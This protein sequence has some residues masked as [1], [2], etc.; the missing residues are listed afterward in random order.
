MAYTHSK[1]VFSLDRFVV[2]ILELDKDLFNKN[3]PILM[4][5]KPGADEQIKIPGIKGL[6][7]VYKQFEF[8]SRK[9]MVV[10]GH[11]DTGDIQKH[12]DLAALRAE[13][14]VC[15][16]QG[17]K[18]R[19][20]EISHANQKI[21]DYQRIMFYF[22][23]TR[24]WACNP[25]NI[26]DKWD[27]DKTHKAIKEFV[28]GW[29][30]KHTP[31]MVETLADTVKADTKKLW[32]KKLW[33]AVFDLYMEELC[34]AMKIRRRPPAKLPDP[35]RLPRAGLKFVKDTKKFVSCGESFPLE[36]L[37]DNTEKGKNKYHY[38]KERKVDILFYFDK[39]GPWTPKGCNNPCP[40]KSANRH[41]AANCPLWRKN[42]FLANYL[43]PTKELEAI[44]YH[45]QFKYYNRIILDSN[46]PKVLNV[47][48]GLEV[49]AYHYRT[50]GNKNTKTEIKAI[51]QFNDGVYTVKVH[52]DYSRKNI[53]FEFD[54]KVTGTP[55]K[56]KWI[57]TKDNTSTPG[58]KEE[59]DDDIKKLLEPE[60][61][62]DRMKYYDLPK[63]WSSQNYWTHYNDGSDKAERFEKV[64]KDRLKLKPYPPRK[65]TTTVDKPLIFSLDDIVLIYN[66]GRQRLRDKK[67]TYNSGT[68]TYSEAY[69]ALSNKSQISLLHIDGEELKLYKPIDAKAPYNSK[70][71]FEGNKRN[72]ITDVPYNT[73]AVVFCNKVYSVF[74]QRVGQK[75]NTFNPFSARKEV[76]GCR[77]AAEKDPANHCR[78]KVYYTDSVLYHASGVGNFELHYIHNGCSITSVGNPHAVKV[79]SFLLVY[80]NGHFIRKAGVNAAELKKYYQDGLLNSVNRWQG[81]GYLLEPQTLGTGNKGKVQIKPVFFFEAKLN[82]LGGKPKCRVSITNS[83][84]DG[85]MGPNTSKMYKLDYQPRNCYT[86]S[87]YNDLDGKGYKTLVVA[88]EIGHAMGLDDDY[89]YDDGDIVSTSRNT[90]DGHYSQYYLGMPYSFSVAAPPIFDSV[91]NETMAPRMKHIWL[92]VN[93]LNVAT[94][95]TNELKDLFEGA[96]Y[97]IV[98]RYGTPVKSLNYY[99]K[100]TAAVGTTPAID[101]RNILSPHKSGVLG[102][103]VGGA[104]R[105]P[106]IPPNPHATPPKPG[107]PEKPAIDGKAKVTLALYKLGEDEMA[108]QIKIGGNT[109]AWAF[110]GLVSV[111]IKVGLDFKNYKASDPDVTKR[112]RWNYKGPPNPP[113][114]APKKKDWLK[115]LKKEITDLN[116]KFYLESTDANSDFRRIYVYFFP[117][118]VD[119]TGKSA[120]H[121]LRTKAHYVIEVAY[122][123]TDKIESRAT[124]TT[125]LKVGNK[126][127]KRWLANYI[128]GRDPKRKAAANIPAP[129]VAGATI[130][131]ED[132]KFIRDWIRTQLGDA[133]FTV[134][135][136]V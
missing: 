3:S 9:R 106:A 82:R 134:K 123:D 38:A 61:L 2:D 79:R 44:A 89:S 75:A 14:I 23:K 108:R 128:L 99:L 66:N 118:I 111:Y 16:L 54:T 35:A 125:N 97:K 72:L 50:P 34:R 117:V 64:L 136:A 8:D 40:P 113:P 119:C 56:S 85:S 90:T 12:Y 67:F 84:N 39:E 77:A 58:I 43:D 29:N 33:E 59:K 31:T 69:V 107:V 1:N 7:A 36:A 88:H 92:H 73:R 133:T 87:T 109:P 68:K 126:I 11:T 24:N 27:D 21:E 28:K 71:N 5:A 41:V 22:H 83:A 52:D 19:W 102:P 121:S 96:K 95:D 4:P 60:K 65:K 15:L 112:R 6:A 110:D 62:P 98:L 42:Y 120:T 63:E 114:V 101:Y 37:G 127:Y 51:T 47:P 17:T 100:K 80:W 49:K 20:V 91:M 76:K 81:K 103:Y 116:K 122:N 115:N 46:K 132:L 104:P 129:A 55:A 13:S 135:D 124:S 10:A 32:P 93:R 45:L 48:G 131:K 86:A 78:M 105:V 53:H 57:Y 25:V 94:G 70:I 26:D 130:K 18:N 30:K 74:D